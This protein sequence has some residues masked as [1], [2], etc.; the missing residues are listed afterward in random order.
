MQSGDLLGGS[1]E[2][3]VTLADGVSG[4]QLVSKLVVVVLKS[5]RG[6]VGSVSTPLAVSGVELS[7]GL[8]GSSESGVGLTDR[9]SGSQLVTVHVVPVLQSQNSSSVGR[10]SA[11]LANGE[12]VAAIAGGSV[13]VSTNGRPGGESGGSTEVRGGGG[14]SQTGGELE[15]SNS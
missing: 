3:G 4:G 1:A 7:A 6:A 10:L 12:S 5:Q 9:V 8:E 13:S 11:P 14:H 15:S 2:S